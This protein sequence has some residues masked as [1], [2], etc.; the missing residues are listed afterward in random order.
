LRNLQLSLAKSH[1]RSFFIKLFL[2]GRFHV[3]FIIIPMEVVEVVKEV[4]E[5]KL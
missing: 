3:P 2:I 1:F 5:E 4:A